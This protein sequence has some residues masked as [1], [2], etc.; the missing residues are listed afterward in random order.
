[1]NKQDARMI[2]NQLSNMV[3]CNIDVFD[4]NGH[5]IYGNNNGINND[6]SSEIINSLLK[7]NIY[8]LNANNRIIHLYVTVKSDDTVISFVKFSDQENLSPYISSIMNQ[9]IHLSIDYDKQ[10]FTDSLKERSIRDFGRDLIEDINEEKY[11]L[12][13]KN[14]NILD[15]DLSIPRYIIAFDYS[16]N[17]LDD[18]NLSE[19]DLQS[20]KN[21]I[22]AN[23]KKFIDN[24]IFFNLTK[25]TYVLLY[26]IKKNTILNLEELYDNFASIVSRKP[27]MGVGYVCNSIFNYNTSLNL[28]LSAISYGRIIKKDQYIFRWDEFQIPI[29]MLSGNKKMRDAILN[30][31]SDLIDYL[32]SHKEITRTII[33]FFDCGMNVDKTAAKLHYH[34]NTILYRLNCFVND[35]NINIFNSKN[36]SEVYNLSLLLKAEN[37]N[38]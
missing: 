30:A 24:S 5:F 32:N 28:A 38:L 6:L 2:V 25:E 27:I 11:L 34:R 37:E 29:L 8:F 17:F 7:D 1:M 35:S 18:G 19:Y 26:E 9:Y 3:D 21:Y 16:D 13:Q 33:E 20:F 10:F 4:I 22:Y 23:T 36:C 14:A 31:S 12:C 15:I